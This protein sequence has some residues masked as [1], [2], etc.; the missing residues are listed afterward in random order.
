[1]AFKTMTQYNEERYGGLFMLRNDKDYADVIFLYRSAD[2]VLIADGHYIN[3]PDYTGYVHCL[4]KGCPACG[5]GIRVQH[6]LFIPLYNITSGQVEFWDRNA[7]FENQL[8]NDVF[9]RY[10]NPS[11]FV[12]RIKRNG[13]SGDINTTYEITA[14][15][16]NTVKSYNEILAEN[17]IIMPDYFSNVIKEMDMGEMYTAL[18][19]SSDAANNSMPSGSMPDYHVTPRGSVNRS[20][21]PTDAPAFN[22]PP[23]YAGSDDL[24]GYVPKEVTDIPDVPN[25]G[26]A[27][28][29]TEGG[30]DGDDEVPFDEGVK[31]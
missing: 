5:K 8:I 19:T 11:D 17:K 23:A 20:N 27:V 18:N 25:I 7:R 6:K 13:V 26:P 10:P 28:D 31:F 4:G 9:S 24:G 30:D 15:A 12:F 1:M 22:E 2:D 14:V 21:A 16:K 29:F 3:T